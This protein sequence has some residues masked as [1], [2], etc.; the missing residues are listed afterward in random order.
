[1][2]FYHGLMVENHRK[3][4]VK[5]GGLMGFNQQN[6]DFNGMYPLVNVY[7]LLLNMAIEIVDLPTKSMVIFHN[8]VNVCQRV[9]TYI[10]V[11]YEVNVGKYSS[12]MEHMGEY[13]DNSRDSNNVV[14][15]IYI[16]IA[17]NSDNNSGLIS[18]GLYL[19]F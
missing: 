19:Y 3:M 13:G 1:M 2:L 18:Y 10:W 5:D 16:Y 9:F 8:Y 11:I 12:T 14:I 6:G 4:V 15:Y 7:S 17:N